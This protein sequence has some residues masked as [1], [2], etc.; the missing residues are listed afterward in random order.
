MS[1]LFM[2]EPKDIVE[3]LVKGDAGVEGG[4]DGGGLGIYFGTGFLQLIV[5]GTLV[6]G[7]LLERVVIVS[8]GEQDLP[9]G[10]F[11]KGEKVSMFVPE[12]NTVSE[13]IL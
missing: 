11:C 4:G 1:E 13:G 10:T 3:S 7:G 9:L 2:A 12:D 8:R 6:Q 5:F